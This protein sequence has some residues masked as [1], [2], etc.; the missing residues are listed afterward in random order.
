MAVV[1]FVV[2]VHVVSLITVLNAFI[3]VHV[4]VIVAKVVLMGKGSGEKVHVSNLHTTSGQAHRA[5]PGK[6]D[7]ARN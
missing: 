1:V 7:K 3:A 4:I 2:V 6:D 5:V